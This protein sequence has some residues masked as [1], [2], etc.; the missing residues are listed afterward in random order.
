M[1]FFF[2]RNLTS[3]IASLPTTATPAP[4]VPTKP[5][6]D[7][8]YFALWGCDEKGSYIKPW[9]KRVLGL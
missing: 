7:A 1:F 3:S 9:W 5:L 6:M 2:L 8:E 4:R